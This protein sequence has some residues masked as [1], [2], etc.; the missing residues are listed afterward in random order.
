MFSIFKLIKCSLC[1]DKFVFWKWILGKSFIHKNYTET[2]ETM[3][4]HGVFICHKHWRFL[5]C[6]LGWDFWNH[7]QKINFISPSSMVFIISLGISFS[8]SYLLSLTH[9][10]YTC[11]IPTHNFVHI[12]IVLGQKKKKNP[13]LSFSLMAE[14]INTSPIPIMFKCYFA[15][16]SSFCDYS[17]S[18][19]ET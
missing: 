14:L 10:I 3:T 4:S 18:S 13:E 19:L 7:C 2:R 15:S 1:L 16:T 9:T 5:Y 12:T 17:N 11:V 8:L 6:H